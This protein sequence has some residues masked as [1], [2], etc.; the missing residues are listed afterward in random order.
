MNKRP[1]GSIRRKLLKGNEKFLA[2][3]R[4][5]LI[6]IFACVLGFCGQGP[7]KQKEVQVSIER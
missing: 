1:V 2:L 6:T 3:H 7:F 5:E 4:F